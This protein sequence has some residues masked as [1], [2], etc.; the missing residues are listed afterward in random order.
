MQNNRNFFAKMLYRNFFAIIFVK[1][2]TN[3]RT[4]GCTNKEFAKEI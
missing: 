2:L 4:D 3:N 1:V